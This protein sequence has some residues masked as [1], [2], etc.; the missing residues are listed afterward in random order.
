MSDAL[1]FVLVIGMLVLLAMR[2]VGPV[3]ATPT[4]KALLE[5]RT[6]FIDRVLMNRMQVMGLL[7]VLVLGTGAANPRWISQPVFVLA[8]GGALVLLTVRFKYTFSSDGFTTHASGLRAWAD[9]D[10]YRFEGRRVVLTGSS[11]TRRVTLYVPHSAHKE[12]ERVFRQRGLKRW[13]P[14]PAKQTAP[15]GAR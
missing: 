11:W 1:G 2:T 7:V 5:V 3:K 10:T 14:D 15:R 6:S 13:Q 9:C 4:G 8:V 12:L